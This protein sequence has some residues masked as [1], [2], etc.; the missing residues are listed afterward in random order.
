MRI[1]HIITRLIV[2]GAQENT[3]LTCEGLAERGHEVFLWAGPTTGPEGSLVERARGGAYRYEEFPDLIRAVS[4]W[5]DFRARRILRQRLDELKPDVVHT[6][7]SKAGVLGRLAA[8]QARVPRIVHTIH[9]MS[10]NRT[11][12]PFTRAAYAAAERYCARRC[13]KIVSVADEMT[14][15]ARAA[16]IGQ[17]AQYVTVRSGIVTADFDPARFD[18]PESRRAFGLPHDRILV[19]SVAR[20][21]KNKGYD[22]LLDIMQQAVAADPRLHFVW[23][24]DGAGRA[25]YEGELARRGLRDRTSLTGLIPPEKIPQLLAG[26]DILLHTSRWEG[27]PRAV[28][29]ALLMEKPAISF[30]IDGA[31]E[32]I[33]SGQT[34]FTAPL[35]DVAGMTQAVLNLARD[36]DLRLRMGTAGRQKCLAEFD[37]RRMVDRLERLYS[38]LPGR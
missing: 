17:P 29:Q 8:H 36:S 18:P 34:G 15:Q 19:A 25:F 12:G 35:D 28:V 14:R 2:G 4:P 26:I 37:H 30:A 21:F 10:F 13:H 16:G 23:I 1:V 27:L 31:P 22:E 7:S 6:H 24:G 3:I 32:V 38:E 5:H 33:I 11:Q 20:L 9:G